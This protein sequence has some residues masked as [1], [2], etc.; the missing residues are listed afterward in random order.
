MSGWSEGSGQRL[1]HVA[2][3]G[4]VELAV[5]VGVVALARFP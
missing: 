5:I 3:G 2:V 4:L 1:E